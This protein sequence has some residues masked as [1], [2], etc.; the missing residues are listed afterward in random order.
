[1]YEEF[2]LL[3]IVD[4]HARKVG[5]EM[6]VDERQ[7]V[8]ALPP[9]LKCATTTALIEPA[10]QVPQRPRISVFEEFFPCQCLGADRLTKPTRSTGSYS[11]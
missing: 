2:P 11:G 8:G 10:L 4:N 5:D 1:M 7:E 6:D 9:A 3:D